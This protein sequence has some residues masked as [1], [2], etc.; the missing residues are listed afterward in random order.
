MRRSF[1]IGTWIGYAAG[2]RLSQAVGVAVSLVQGAEVHPD[3]IEYQDGDTH[4]TTGFN[5]AAAG[6]LL[7]LFALYATWW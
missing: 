5:G 6:I 3:A 4:T 7:M 2:R 1:V